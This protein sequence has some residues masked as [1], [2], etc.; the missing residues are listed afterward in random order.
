MEAFLVIGSWGF[1]CLFL[2]FYGPTLMKLWLHWW[3]LLI[4]WHFHLRFLRGRGL[5]H[6]VFDR[7]RG[8]LW[9]ER[10]LRPIHLVHPISGLL[11]RLHLLLLM[12]GLLHWLPSAPEIGSAI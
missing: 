1:R 2:Q 7:D 4:L 3:G 9:L 12:N 6:V 5:V 8:F 10:L 11:L